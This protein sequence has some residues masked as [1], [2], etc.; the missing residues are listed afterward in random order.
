MQLHST[1]FR[2]KRGHCANSE[3]SQGL[4][5]ADM[6]VQSRLVSDFDIVEAILS[7]ACYLTDTPVV[8]HMLLSH[9]GSFLDIVSA[10]HEQLLDAGL[11][12]RTAAAFKLVHLASKRVLK[13]KMSNLPLLSNYELLRD[14]LMS[15]FSHQKKEEVRVLFLDSQGILL[16]DECHSQG[17]INHVQ[18]YPREIV[19]RALELNSA[20]IISV[21]NHPSDCL[22]PSNDDLTIILDLKRICSFF[23][24]AVHD[25]VIISGSGMLSL[26]ELKLI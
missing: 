9:F 14:Y 15:I 2:K 5:D 13:E 23:S 18:I 3:Y 24:I 25:H 7:F 1:K 26:N 8:T 4:T 21:H 12:K 22:V 16:L 6:G 11:D 17:T 10:T 20:A 19:K